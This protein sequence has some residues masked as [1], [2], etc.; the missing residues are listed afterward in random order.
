MN[1]GDEMTTN[2]IDAKISLRF[3]NLTVDLIRINRS[4]LT[5]NYPK[6]SHGKNF[7][8]LHYIDG[9]KGTM[10]CSDEEYQVESGSLIMTGPLVPHEQITDA[11]CHMIEYC[12]EFEIAEDKNRRSSKESALLKDT[13]F[14]IGKDTQNIAEKFRRLET[15][16]V[17]MNIGYM[18]AVKSIITEILVDLI[19]NY[20]GCAAYQSLTKT[21]SSD[22]RAL[23][24]DEMFLFEYATI[25]LDNLSNKLGLSPRQ[26]QRFLRKIYGKNF[27][28][29]RTEKRQE[30][31]KELVKNGM[32]LQKAANEVGYESVRSLK[33]LSEFVPHDPDSDK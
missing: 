21:A 6:H 16:H 32:S 22:K 7:Y 17:Q 11:R 29:L 3:D 18:Q 31:A 10:I 13:V 14:W 28:E 24:A 27:L 19:R 1:L 15:E 8:E 23:I 33:N 2:I 30:K 25:T 9:G 20:T 5:R 26:T 12:F 4:V